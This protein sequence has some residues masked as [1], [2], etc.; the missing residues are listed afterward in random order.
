MK[1]KLLLAWALCF[2]ASSVFAQ[3]QGD[4]GLPRGQKA[5]LSTH[6]PQIVFQEPDVAA[7]RAEDAIVD[8]E[9]SGPWR[10]GYNNETNLTLENAGEWTILPNG[11]KIWRLKLVCSK[12]LTVNLTLDKVELPVGN[13]LYVYNADKS[14]ILGKFTAKHLYEGQ[15]G[16]EL[17]PGNTAIIEYY[18][19]PENKQEDA[20]LRI[21]T[22]THGYRTAAEF[23]E[24]AFGSSGSCNMNVNCP[25]GAS[26]EAQKRGA[27]MLVSGS[28]GFCSGSMIN[29]T[30]NDGTPYVLT[31]NHCGSS[32][33]ASWIFRFNWES[34]TCA[35]PGA[36][37]TFQSLSGSV[38]RAS[39]Q[40]SD[41]RLVEITGGLENGTVPA[42]YNTYFSGWD[43]S[44]TIPSTTVCIHHPSGDI[45]KI[46]FDDAAASAV[47]A[48]GSSEPAS[49]WQ[50][51]WDRN[52]TTEGGSSGSPLFDQNGR[53]I[54][55]LWGG[56]ASCSNLSAPDYYGRV[57]N[58]WEPSGSANSG[59]LKHWLDPTSSG[60]TFIDGYDP[61]A[62]TVTD[63]AGINQV[64]SPSG[65]ACNTSVSPQV[66][67]RN[68]GANNLTSA[69]INY[70][71]DGGTNNTFSWSGTLTPGATALVTLPSLTTTN[72][73]HV[74]NASTSMPN[75]VAD[76]NPANDNAN[77]NFSVSNGE[78]VDIIINT[79]CWGYETYWE[80]ED[81]SSNVVASG[82]NEEFVMPGGTESASGGDDGAYGDEMTITTT[83][84]LAQGCYDFTIYDDFGDGLLGTASG[85]DIDGSYTIE[86]GSG[87]ELAAIQTVNF[88]NSETNP[89]CVGE[90]SSAGLNELNQQTLSI[91][92]NPNNGSFT[93]Q[94][95]Q[96]A[97]EEYQIRM[98]DLSG[99]EVY[100]ATE[101]AAMT[102]LQLEGLS[103]G[104]YMLHIQSATFNVN[105][106][107]M[108]QR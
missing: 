91:Y 104:T 95:S 92:P 39:R 28:N 27:V 94:L 82:G 10:F 72:G 5:A 31:A 49:S 25:D 38:S 37:P 107:V 21:H 79:D 89:F 97:G 40:P 74:F 22:V 71:I 57:F 65:L 62:V 36:S 18:V 11:S 12:A 8:A 41:F 90:S 76:T 42:A 32:G 15:L 23:A 51:E 54:G 69:T 80:I 33:F 14:F 56:G 67:L 30:Q 50:V 24:K 103:T 52:T 102:E 53:I 19:A 86:D 93:I 75:G 81:A 45:K 29:N 9:K 63:D 83:V 96:D 84:C 101:T 99:R 87:T 77:A 106:A 48:M 44:G 105:E 61:N 100:V 47:Q 16:T 85:C 46:S 2:A 108:I 13:E 60:V 17:V 43:N 34:A 68:F 3:V 4:G 20:A 6:I 98:L 64:N 66:T 70:N 55:Q 59:Q 1:K 78:P 73:A 88:G 7:L 35:N 58:S 26:W